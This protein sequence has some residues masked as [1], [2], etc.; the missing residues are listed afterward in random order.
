VIDRAPECL[1]IL[2][3][4]ALRLFGIAPCHEVGILSVSYLKLARYASSFDAIVNAF[5]VSNRRH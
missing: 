3:T 4:F 5:A 2:R 1:F